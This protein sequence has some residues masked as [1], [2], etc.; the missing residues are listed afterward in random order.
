LGVV[1][2]HPNIPS[3]YASDFTRDGAPYLAMEFL[4]NSLADRIDERGRWPQLS[5]FGIARLEG[6]SHT[7]SGIITASLLYAANEVLN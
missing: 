1:S 7:Q 2:Q 3:V 6:R 5:D 4:G